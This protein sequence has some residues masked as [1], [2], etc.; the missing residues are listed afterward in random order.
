MAISER[1]RCIRKKKGL[2]QKDLGVA[3][4][5][6]EQ[7]A[8]IRISQYESG[9]RT[10]KR[11]IL[12][13]M[14]SALDVSPKALSVPDIDGET[15]LLFTLFAL[16]DRYGFQICRS[17]SHLYLMLNESDKQGPQLQELLSA[18]SSYAEM[19]KTGKITKKEYDQWRYTFRQIAGK[20]GCKTQGAGGRRK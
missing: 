18:W 12:E 6:S 14:A 16:E 2:T 10:P 17:G 19:L 20:S 11:E 9:S 3:I 1:I 7:V 15:D 5:F 4:G 13:K 8:E